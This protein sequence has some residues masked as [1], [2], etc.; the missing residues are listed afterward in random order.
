MAW[1]VVGYLGSISWGLAETLLAL[2]HK[3]E[4]LHPLGHRIVAL[5]REPKTPGDS[6]AVGCEEIESRENAA[7]VAA[8]HAAA[9]AKVGYQAVSPGH[10]DHVRDVRGGQRSTGI[11]G[12]RRHCSASSWSRVH[13]GLAVLHRRRRWESSHIIS[14]GI[15]VVGNLLLRSWVIW[16]ARMDVVGAKAKTP[17]F[18]RRLRFNRW[19]DRDKTGR[20]TL[21][22]IQ[23]Q[24]EAYGDVSPQHGLVLL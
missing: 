16:R 17:P 22:S 6:T 12:I 23:H 7:T 18:A 11:T 1:E 13:R 2:G 24:T 19:S 21:R 14:L 20:D 5:S 15:W 3:S 8:Q 10:M 4:T 9:S